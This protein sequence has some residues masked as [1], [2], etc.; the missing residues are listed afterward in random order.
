MALAFKKLRRESFLLNE[1]G[2]TLSP[3]NII[4]LIQLVIHNCH[5]LLPLPL[6]KAV[7]LPSRPL[8][9]TDNFIYINELICHPLLDKK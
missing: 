6:L 4:C 5:L 7:K 2:I 8:M 1:L 9:K 3:L